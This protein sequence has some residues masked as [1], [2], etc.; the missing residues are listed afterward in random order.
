[1]NTE[2]RETQRESE[3]NR[4]E[5]GRKDH[6]SHSLFQRSFTEVRGTRLFRTRVPPRSGASR[7]LVNA[8]ATAM[9]MASAFVKS[10]CHREAE[11]DS[12]SRARPL[13]APATEERMRRHRSPVYLET[14]VPPRKIGRAHV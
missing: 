6:G 7:I 4:R 11:A 5:S 9:R 14:H 2:A 10:V 1:M 13:N 12:T 3:G 8:C